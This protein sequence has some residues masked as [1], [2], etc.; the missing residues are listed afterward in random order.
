[1]YVANF[2]LGLAKQAE[3]LNK[4]FLLYLVPHPLEDN[5]DQNK[6]YE[7]FVLLKKFIRCIDLANEV[8]KLHILI[9]LIF[10]MSVLSYVVYFFV[11]IITDSWEWIVKVVFAT[12]DSADFTIMIPYILGIVI[13][14]RNAQ[15]FLRTILE[16]ERIL[17]NT[18]TETSRQLV[19]N[20][21]RSLMR[22]HHQPIRITAHL[23]QLDY[24]FLLHMM[25]FITA[26]VI[27]LIQFKQLEDER[28]K[29][30]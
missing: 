28:E 4:I 2:I 24:R 7:V 26:N 21:Q 30:F 16:T 9:N 6:K 8:F 20:G 1:M 22:C 25:H 3:V 29:G 14:T 11:W 17:K 5:R 19:Y 10:S 12:A 23:Y 18:L 15:V 13:L 27:I